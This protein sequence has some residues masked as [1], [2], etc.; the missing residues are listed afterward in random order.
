MASEAIREKAKRPDR[1]KLFLTFTGMGLLGG[2]FG[3]LVM[4]GV[5]KSGFKIHEVRPWTFAFLPVAVLAAAGFHELGHV[6]AGMAQKFRFYLLAVG[7]LLVERMGATIKI[8]LNRMPAWWG[9]IAACVPREFSG[10]LRKKMIWYTAG[11]PMF[12]FLGS[13]V[14]A[15]GWWFRATS[16]SAAFVLIL[17]GT[18]SA[19]LTVVT[20]LPLELSGAAS[21]GARLLMLFRH[22]PE[23][24]R[25]VALAALSGL[26]LAQ[27]PREWPSELITI[28]GESDG[29]PGSVWSSVL[30]HQWY[31]DRRELDRASFWL[32]RGLALDEHLAKPARAALHLV[33]AKF[34]ARYQGNAVAA[35]NYFNSAAECQLHLPGDLNLA[36]AAVYRLEGN[37]GAAESE[38]AVA[39]AALWL[40]PENIAAAMREEIQDLRL[41]GA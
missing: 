31:L 9:G 4:T 25:W 35:R 6:L 12:S 36:A 41:T 27:R 20:L 34:S 3:Y 14:L 19:A 21:D 15:V 40:R 26:S 5:V 37:H 23:G 38:L 16:P 33:A 18:I 10:N 8:R 30:R 24:E 11:G 29:K 1:K 28:L 7:P 13:G 39:E 32:E 17:F 2:V 22:R